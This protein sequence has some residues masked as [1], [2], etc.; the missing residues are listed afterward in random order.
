MTVAKCNITGIDV[1]DGRKCNEVHPGHIVLAA[2][3][4]KKDEYEVADIEEDGTLKAMDPDGKEVVF[5]LEPESEEICG[6]I[7]KDLIAKFK[8][9][10]AKEGSEVFFTIFV[11]TAPVGET[12]PVLKSVILEFKEG[13]D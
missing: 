6:P 10:A 3:D 11:T 9:N 7:H 5:Q 8:E 1:L 13:K 2:F 4:I 12:D